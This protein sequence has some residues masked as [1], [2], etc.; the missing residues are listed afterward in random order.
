MKKQRYKNVAQF[1]HLYARHFYDEPGCF[2]CGEDRQCLDHVPPL[3]I[4]E[5]ATPKELKAMKIPFVLIG[6]CF[7][8][9]AML[10]AKP[11]AVVHE[12]LWFLYGRLTDK[13][14]REATLWDDEE[15][16]EMSPMFQKMIRARQIRQSILI[17]RIRKIEWRMAHS[18]THPDYKG[19][20]VQDLP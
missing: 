12:R 6:S 18:E 7:E 5:Y 10:G 16:A 17:D 15:I 2:Y 9:N 4:V 1:K 19:K 8:C 20:E 13:Y 14:E 11:L 3:H